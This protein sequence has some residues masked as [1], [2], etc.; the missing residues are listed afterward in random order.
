M[1]DQIASTPGLL[2]ALA[3]AHARAREH[4]WTLAGAPERVTIDVDATLITSHS[5]SGRPTFASCDDEHF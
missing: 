4:V 1:I 5:D 3:D 2:D